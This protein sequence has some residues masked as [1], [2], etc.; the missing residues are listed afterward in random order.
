[1][2]KLNTNLAILNTSYQTAVD[3]LH[4]IAADESNGAQNDAG[5]YAVYNQ[6]ENALNALITAALGDPRITNSGMLQLQE[7]RRWAAATAKRFR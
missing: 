5:I 6:L 4:L 1:M 2:Y 7:H 3:S